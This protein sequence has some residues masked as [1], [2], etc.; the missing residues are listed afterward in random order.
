VDWLRTN[1]SLCKCPTPD[2][3]LLDDFASTVH[4]VVDVFSSDP[5]VIVGERMDIL[6]E[7]AIN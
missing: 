2:I 3:V 4:Y 6:F 7:K 1:K 5:F